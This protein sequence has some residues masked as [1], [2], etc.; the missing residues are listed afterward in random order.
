MELRY[1]LFSGQTSNP[2]F[3]F[4]TGPLQLPRLNPRLILESKAI[5]LGHLSGNPYPTE[6]AHRLQ[7]QPGASC[8]VIGVSDTHVLL[9]NEYIVELNPAKFNILNQILN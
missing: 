5:N 7:G 1:T 9:L 6:L 8:L 3:Q 2:D 4:K